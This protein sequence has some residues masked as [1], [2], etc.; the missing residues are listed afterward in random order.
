MVYGAKSSRMIFMRI[1]SIAEGIIRC[2]VSGYLY[3][4]NLPIL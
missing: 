2:S 3:L 4:N 1:E